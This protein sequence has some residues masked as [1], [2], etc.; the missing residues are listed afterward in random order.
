MTCIKAGR[1][2]GML[3]PHES[4]SRMVYSG[5]LFLQREGGQN[6]ICPSYI[7]EPSLQGQNMSTVKD[8]NKSS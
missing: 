6:T 7:T 8:S 3:M 2:E 4:Q 5:G 1:V